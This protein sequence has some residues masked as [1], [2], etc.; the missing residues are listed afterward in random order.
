MQLWLSRHA[1]E[2]KMEIRD[3]LPSRILP[4]WKRG[5]F[6][7]ASRAVHDRLG[8]APGAAHCNEQARAVDLIHFRRKVFRHPPYQANQHRIEG[9][10]GKSRTHRSQKRHCAAVFSGFQDENAQETRQQITLLLLNEKHRVENTKEPALHLGT[11]G[12]T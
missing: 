11:L 12:G 4:L 9:G 8:Q 10:N 7:T 3:T 5:E 2:Q 6:A 1:K